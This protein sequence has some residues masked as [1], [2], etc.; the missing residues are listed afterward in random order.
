MMIGIW[1]PHYMGLDQEGED[2]KS[3]GQSTAPSTI[4]T[5][6]IQSLKYLSI[7]KLINVL[8]VPL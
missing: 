1:G 5:L 6:H 4:T 2:L 3:S 7:D 8:T